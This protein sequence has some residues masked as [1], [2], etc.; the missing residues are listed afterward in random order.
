MKPNEATINIQTITMFG[1]KSI[2]LDPE[3]GWDGWRIV[4]PNEYPVDIQLGSCS[5]RIFR[6]ETR[7]I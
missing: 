5:Y 7:L 3:S 4:N 2:T 1:P 6:F